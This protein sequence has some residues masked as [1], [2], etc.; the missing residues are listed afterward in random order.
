MGFEAK[1]PVKFPTW[2]NNTSGVHVEHG[3]ENSIT[4]CLVRDPEQTPTG[5]FLCN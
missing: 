4:Q 5:E 1:K 3:P 2:F